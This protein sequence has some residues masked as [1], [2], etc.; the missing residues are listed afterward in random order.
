MT[1]H[2][3]ESITPLPETRL[4]GADPG[5]LV[6]EAQAGAQAAAP[7]D[8]RDLSRLV[9]EAHLDQASP[10]GPAGS[11]AILPGLRRQGDSDQGG[12][13]GPR[14]S[15]SWG[16]GSVRQPIQPPEPV[17]V[18]P[19]PEDGPG[20]GGRAQKSGSNLTANPAGSYVRAADARACL[21]A[22]AQAGAQ[23]GEAADLPP[24]PKKFWAEARRPR[25][26][27]VCDKNSLNR[28]KSYGTWRCY[29]NGPNQDFC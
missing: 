19:R 1:A 4:P 9:L 10:A 20:A 3:K 21:S 11:G 28:K 14:G 23:G 7:Q 17:Q 13:G 27:L 12:C 5:W 16:L 18:P 6:R 25:C 15:I 26:S 29:E 8:Q 24:T 2:G 22:D